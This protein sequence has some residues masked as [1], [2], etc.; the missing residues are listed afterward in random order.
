MKPRI[1]GLTQGSKTVT[2]TLEEFAGSVPPAELLLRFPV[3]DEIHRT[4]KVEAGIAEQVRLVQAGGGMR[5]LRCGITKMRPRRLRHAST[6]AACKA[7][8][9]R[10]AASISFAVSAVN[11]ASAGAASWDW[12]RLTKKPASIKSF[13]VRH[14]RRL[15]L[16]YP[17]HAG[18]PSRLCVKRHQ[19]RR[20]P[21]T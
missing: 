14:G 10:C 5:G 18:V 17:E 7:D 8:S 4:G 12:P 16:A 20:T 3:G 2:P 9:Q 1:S 13:T 11:S 6:V 15:R 19:R 21:V